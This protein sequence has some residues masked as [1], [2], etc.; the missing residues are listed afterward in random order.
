MKG[1]LAKRNKEWIVS[2]EEDGLNMYYPLHP[3]DVKICKQYG[4][5]S[6]DWEGKQVEYEV[7][8][9]FTHPHLY[10]GVGWGDGIVYAK[11]MEPSS[12]TPKIYES[13]DGGNTIYER[14]AGNYINRVQRTPK[15]EPIEA[16]VLQSHI[17]QYSNDQELGGFIRKTYR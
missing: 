17:K 15:K 4:D 7:V 1:I 10:E 12:K 2:I 16:S 9:E 6:L 13:P 5:Y 11:L 8:D 3:D 14:E